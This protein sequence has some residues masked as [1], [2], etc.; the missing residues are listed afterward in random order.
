M[1]SAKITFTWCFDLVCL[2]QQ[3]A[4]SLEG[5]TWPP[6]TTKLTLSRN[7][8]ASLEGVV[9]PPDMTYLNLGENQIASLEGVAWPP[10]M[11]HLALGLNEITSLKG[12]PASL[13]SLY[14][15]SNPIATLEHLPADLK[16]LELDQ[17]PITSG[18]LPARLEL[19]CMTWDRPPSCIVAQALTAAY[20][21]VLRYTSLATTDGYGELNLAV[22]VPLNKRPARVVL[23]VLSSSSVP[24]VGLKAAVRRL[25]RADLVREMAGMLG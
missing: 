17:C 5:V 16:R 21:E 7:Q 2:C 10:G 11:T 6:N 24:R 23:V 4:T 1:S 22:Q 3:G 14:M 18:R 15:G 8:I 12:L 20:C 9:W 25:H 13:T 19:L